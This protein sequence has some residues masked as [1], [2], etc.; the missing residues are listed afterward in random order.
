MAYIGNTPGVSSQ[1]YVQRE[2][3]A[4]SPKSAFIV[5][6]GYSLGYVDVIV[7]GSQLDE[8]DFTAADGVTVTLAQAAAVG[9]IVRIIA[10]LPRGLSDGYLKSEVDA[11][12]VD[13]AGDTMTGALAAVAGSASA[14]G[15]AIS[16]DANT[17]LYSPGADQIGLA[18]GGLGRVIIDAGGRVTMPYQ[19]AFHVNG[20][21]YSVRSSGTYS[22]ANSSA[23]RQVIT[24]I[25]GHFNTANDRFTA[26]VAGTYEFYV[27]SCNAGTGG[28]IGIKLLKNSSVE[29]S[30]QLCYYSAYQG[31][32]ITA[33]VQL[34]AGDYVE[35]QLLWNNGTS[36]DIYTSSFGGRL[37]G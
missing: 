23:S 21:G 16:G 8:A 1:R 29:L 31:H 11:K 15:L 6:S 28:S 36:G 26:P 20:N 22:A 14:P 17:G 9:D 25:G 18:S 3:I 13:V 24:N 5:T 4:G 7:N 19:P 37:V 30:Y 2:V 12:F 27:C 34:A 10:W 32:A 35:G 33:V